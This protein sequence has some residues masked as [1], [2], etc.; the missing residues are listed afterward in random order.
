M[1]EGGSHFSKTDFVAD[2]LKFR[3]KRFCLSP[4]IRSFA[5][6]W[7]NTKIKFPFLLSAAIALVLPDRVILAGVP[8]DRNRRNDYRKKT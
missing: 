6:Q 7:H 4:I 1:G 8:V 2:K 5:K 3:W